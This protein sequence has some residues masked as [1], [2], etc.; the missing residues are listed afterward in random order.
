M[1]CLT[2]G[3]HSEVLDGVHAAL[4]AW[5]G[6]GQGEGEG[7]CTVVLAARSLSSSYHQYLVP[8]SCYGE[9]VTTEYSTAVLVLCAVV[10][11]SDRH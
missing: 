2:A 4:L 10:V 9:S 6:V 7:R 8:S 1:P 3:H 11:V 5:W